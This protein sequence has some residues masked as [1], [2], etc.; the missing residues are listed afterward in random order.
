LGILPDDFW[1]MTPREMAYLK[2]GADWRWE[3]ETLSIVCAL[4]GKTPDELM[5]RS[6]TLEEAEEDGL[7]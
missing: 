6:R 5:G 7:I 2:E 4:V 1:R 3:R